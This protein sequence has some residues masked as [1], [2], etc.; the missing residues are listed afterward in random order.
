MFIADQHS[1]A[2]N[3]RKPRRRYWW[4]SIAFMLGLWLGF[5]AGH[6]F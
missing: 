2:I 4:A 5:G 1:Y 3:R 6:L